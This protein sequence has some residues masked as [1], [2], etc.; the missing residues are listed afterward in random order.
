MSE[1]SEAFGTI[2]LINSFWQR[3]LVIWKEQTKILQY[4]QQINVDIL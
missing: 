1:R 2:S 4:T 3:A